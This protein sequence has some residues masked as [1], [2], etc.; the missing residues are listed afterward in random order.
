MLEYALG[1]GAY[2]RSATAAGRKD[3]R[4]EWTPVMIVLPV[5]RASSIEDA[6]SSCTLL[7]SC[8]SGGEHARL[9]EPARSAL[10]G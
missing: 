9:L 1:C 8:G 5:T 6:S 4:C 2:S 3:G 10:R 7:P